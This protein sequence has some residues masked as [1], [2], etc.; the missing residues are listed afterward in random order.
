[1]RALNVLL[2]LPLMY[3]WINGSGAIKICYQSANF[4]SSSKWCRPRSPIEF[5]AIRLLSGTCHR[6]VYRQPKSDRTEGVLGLFH[7]RSWRENEERT[8]HMA[9]DEMNKVILSIFNV[10]IWFLMLKMTYKTYPERRSG[11]ALAIANQP[12]AMHGTELNRLGSR[13][14]ELHVQV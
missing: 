13:P 14:D 2:S 7:G 8:F 4:E 11:T 5:C 12:N 3:K 6:N 1:M 9:R 10:L